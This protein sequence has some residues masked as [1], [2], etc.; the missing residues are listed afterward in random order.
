MYAYIYI[1]TYIYIYTYIYNIFLYLQVYFSLYLYLYVYVIIHPCFVFPYLLIHLLICPDLSIV[2]PIKTLDLQSSTPN[3][4]TTPKPPKSAWITP[5]GSIYAQWQSATRVG[6]LRPSRRLRV[7]RPLW[8]SK[9]FGAV[10]TGLGAVGGRGRWVE[11]F[12]WRTASV[13]V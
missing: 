7:S 12:A 6:A 4:C 13:G 8:R 11:G 10:G 1:S 3:H 2:K 5:L 9:P